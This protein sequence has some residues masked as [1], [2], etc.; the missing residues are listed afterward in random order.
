MISKEQD[1]KDFFNS[2]KHAYD[3]SWDRVNHTL[4]VGIFHNENESLQDAYTNST[5][6]LKKLIEQYSKVNTDS[7]I[8]ELCCGTGKALSYLTSIY[9]CNGTGIDI[10]EE[11]IRDAKTHSNTKCNFL[12]ESVSN[13][14]NIT[15]KKPTHIISQDGIFLVHD[16]RKCYS[17]AFNLL[18]NNGL[19]VISDFLSK[20]PIQDLKSDRVKGI[21][22]TVKWE[23]GLSFEEYKILLRE[24]GFKIFFSEERNDDMK[25]TY[26]KLIIQTAPFI[27]K[28]DEVYDS[29]VKRYTQIVHGIDNKEIGWGWFVAKKNSK[30]D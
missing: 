24:T 21:Y 26:E 19:L 1:V 10:S 12:V 5:Q 18:E 16:K 28:R 23:K 17:N 20:K 13:L 8:L 7:H 25:K 30:S 11:Q 27:K 29:L 2:H 22:E 9:D 6:Y 3:N 4:H 15:L 14:E